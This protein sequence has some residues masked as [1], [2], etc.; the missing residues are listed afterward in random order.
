MANRTVV[1]LISDLSGEPDAVTVT[2]AVEDTRWQID[3]T[4]TERDAFVRALAPY[5][6]NARRVRGG[7]PGRAVKA[8]TTR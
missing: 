5:T 7:V 8:A 2:F 1:T 6:E 3:L 4:R